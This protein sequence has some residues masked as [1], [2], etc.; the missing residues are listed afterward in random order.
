MED[1][2]PDPFELESYELGYDTAFMGE[3]KDNPYSPL[4]EEDLWLDYENGY[5]DGVKDLK[6]DLGEYYDNN[7]L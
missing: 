1:F 2:E 7:L 3:P 4:E 5:R 6:N